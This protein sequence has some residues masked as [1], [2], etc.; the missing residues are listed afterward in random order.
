MPTYLLH[1]FRWPR[2][3]IRIHIIL[4]NLDDAAAEWLVAPDTTRTLLR[5]L[6]ELFPEAMEYLGRLRFIEQ[7][8]P[9]DLSA[10]AASQPYAYVADRCEEVKLSVA[11]NDVV[12]RGINNEQWAGMMELRDKLAPEEE[13]GWYVVVCGD[14]ER[15]APPTIG[16]LQGGVHS[17]SYSRSSEGGS[18]SEGKA[19]SPPEEPGPKGLR[20]LFGS[21]RLGGKRKNRPA[22]PPPKS[23]DSVMP[24]LAQGVVSS[25]P[26]Q[27]P[28]Q[29][30]GGLPNGHTRPPGGL[31]NGHARPPGSASNSSGNGDSIS[32]PLLEQKRRTQDLTP[33]TTRAQRRATMSGAPNG[34]P[35]QL[36]THWNPNG[37]EPAFEHPLFDHNMS[38]RNSYVPAFSNSPRATS[39]E[40][41]RA[42]SPVSIMRSGAMSPSANCRGGARSPVS[43]LR[44]EGIVRAES[45]LRGELVS[46]ISNRAMSPARG[47]G[48]I[49]L[50]GNAF[51]Q[52][53]QAYQAAQEH[54]AA[55]AALQG[56]TPQ[57]EPPSE[58]QS[59]PMK[60]ASKNSQ[61]EKK[62]LSLQTNLAP[63]PPVP[64]ED[65]MEEVISMSPAV[66]QP[67]MSYRRS[68]ASLLMS[69]TPG[70]SSSQIN[71]SGMSLTS[72]P[73]KQYHGQNI[74]SNDLVANG[75]ENAFNR[76]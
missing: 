70:A 45:P 14:E 75:I 32:P 37:V 21:A 61:R 34:G 52:Q 24:K 11:V 68:R 1:G 44:N 53:Q 20:K 5:N 23:S 43:T 16:Q 4:Q 55:L 30:L 57:P 7:Y 69:A 26:P 31:A 40:H 59:S 73:H 25:K 66:R 58:P 28:P 74:N 54:Q 71:L 60:S 62:R 72:D 56:H 65:E 19:Q 41:R 47:V 51:A 22:M 46:P 10:G 17:G 2:P 63:P 6:N 3:L 76:L 29:N 27:L 8:D 9:S 15:W 12:N 64:E 33:P 49:A 35:D 48:N 36:A 13:V 42:Y 38:R 39:P 67:V 18:A 50:N